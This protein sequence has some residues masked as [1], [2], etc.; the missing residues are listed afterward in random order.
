MNNEFM[1][2]Y[3]Y[4]I[5]CHEDERALCEMELRSLLGGE[6]SLSS[7]SNYV[8]SSREIEPSRSPFV[9]KRLEVLLKA[10][11][12]GELIERVEGL[13]TQGKSFKAALLNPVHVGAD[14]KWIKLSSEERRSIEREV[15]SRIQGRAE[16]RNPAVVYGFLQLEGSWYFGKVEESVPIWLQHQN[17]PRQYSTALSARVA[18]AIVNI[19]VPC[20]EQVKVIDPCCGIGTVLL[21]ALSMGIDIVGN[22]I[23]PLAAIGARENLAHFQY[24]SIVTLGDMRSLQGHYDVVILDMPYN[25]C[26]VLPDLEKLQLLSS[27]CRLAQRVLIVTT[28][29]MDSILPQAGLEI[30]DRCTVKKG[31]FERHVLVCIA[32]T[33]PHPVS[34]SLT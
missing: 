32:S 18:R 23:N 19:A 12:L 33:D 28:E 27:S 14:G 20:I 22:E 7:A 15:G 13:D 10:D 26:S 25:L 2:Y 6:H 9:K 30:V 3:V 16:L 21:E 29:R 8:L 34:R 4:M 11:A 17:K 1:R 24:K 31:K 5:V